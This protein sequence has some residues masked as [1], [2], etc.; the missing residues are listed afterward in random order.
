MKSPAVHGLSFILLTPWRGIE[1]LLPSF[2]ESSAFS[3]IQLCT[4]R[5]LFIDWFPFVAK[6][7]KKLTPS[8]WHI[9]CWKKGKQIK[10]SMVLNPEE[11][12]VYSELLWT[13]WTASWHQ[14]LGH[15]ETCGLQFECMGHNF[16]LP[17]FQCDV[18]QDGHCHAFYTPV[19]LESNLEEPQSSV[20][21]Q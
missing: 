7:V 16:H 1:E 9:L 19:S 10:Q 8:I 2:L 15:L 11:P 5:L 13:I 6:G 20:M 4:K 3:F 18:I 21:Q 12:V 17:T 14:K